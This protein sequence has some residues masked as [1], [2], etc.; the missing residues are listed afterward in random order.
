MKKDDPRYPVVKRTKPPI[1]EAAIEAKVDA[2]AK[3]HL[4]AMS[5]KL[6]GL[7][8]SHWPDRLFLLPGCPDLYIEFKRPGE[9]STPGQLEVQ[10][11]LRALGRE[12]WTDEDDANECIARMNAWYMR[13]QADQVLAKKHR[14]I[15]ECAHEWTDAGDDHR[16]ERCGVIR[17]GEE[18]H[19]RNER[20][21]KEKSDV[22]PNRR[23]APEVRGSA[24]HP[25]LAR[26]GR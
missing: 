13:C 22:K 24:G 10:R 15:A 25:W 12:V 16:C 20:T 11:Q 5:R 23:V 4:G 6:N 8:F 14:K 19:R 17:S 2:Y 3:Q 21:T 1:K 9:T 18:Q 26:R 7:G